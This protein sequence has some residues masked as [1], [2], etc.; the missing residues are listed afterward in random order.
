[1]A[2]SKEFSAYVIEQLGSLTRVTSRRMFGGVGLYSDG[3]FFG[4]IDDDTLYFKVDDSNRADYERRGSKPFCPFPDKSEF[5][6]SYFDVPADLVE[7]AEALSRWARTS[8]A[9]AL[10]AASKKTK[11]PKTKQVA[12]KKKAVPRKKAKQRAVKRTRGHR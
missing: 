4:L 11:R 10:V 6:M 1:M 8:V 3:L 9:V 2:V 5:S 7:D 12:T